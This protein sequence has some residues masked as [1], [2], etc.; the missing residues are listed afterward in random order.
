MSGWRCWATLGAFVALA[1]AAS[2]QTPQPFPKPGAPTRPQPAPPPAPAPVPPADANPGPAA[3]SPVPATGEPTEQTLGM[4]VY[5]AAQF[6]TS[7]DAGRGQRFYLF[8]TNVEF[9]QIVGYYRTVLR[10][11]GNLVYAEPAVHTFEVGRYRDDAVAFPPGITVKD[12]TWG[13]SEGYL[14]VVAGAPAVR[15]RTII[16]IVPPPPGVVG[17]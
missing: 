17:R 9:A 12:Y 14:H 5:P 10:S 11:R 15:F 4:P 7:Y 3:A 6:L 8:G 13:G 1:A 16:Q 2:A